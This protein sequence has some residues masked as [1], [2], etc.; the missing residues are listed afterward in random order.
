MFYILVASCWLEND[1]LLL[2]LNFSIFEWFN[3]T[4]E[5]NNYSNIDRR[6]HI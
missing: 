2:D 6:S 3:S 1:G 4:S 5:L